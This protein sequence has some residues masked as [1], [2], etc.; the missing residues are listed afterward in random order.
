MTAS[1]GH[2]AWQG[3][4]RWPGAL[5]PFLVVPAGL[6]LPLVLQRRAGASAAVLASLLVLAGGFF[7][8]A[9]VVGMPAPLLL[10]GH[11]G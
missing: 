5:V 7:L 6:V 10:A 1:L 3:F 2:L 4:G 11:R 9:A 8:R